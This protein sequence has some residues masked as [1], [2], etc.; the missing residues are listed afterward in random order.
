M[1]NFK[2]YQLHLNKT[3]F[4]GKNLLKKKCPR[5]FSLDNSTKHVKRIENK[6]IH[7]FF[8]KIEEN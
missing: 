6:Y 1:V 3:V 8:Q 4:W 5:W 7:N 2:T